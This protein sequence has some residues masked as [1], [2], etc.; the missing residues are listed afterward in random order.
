MIAY[1]LPQVMTTLGILTKEDFLFEVSDKHGISIILLENCTQACDA[2]CSR[3]YNTRIL[4]DPA[5]QQDIKG[6]FYHIC[7]IQ[8]RT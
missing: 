4:T 5:R 2:M 1:L 8:K 6:K 3:L 7:R